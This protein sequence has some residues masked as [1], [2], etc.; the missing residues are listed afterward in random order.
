MEVNCLI[1]EICLFLLFCLVYFSEGQH[2]RIGV[3]ECGEFVL[4]GLLPLCTAALN[5]V[6]TLAFYI[7]GGRPKTTV[8]YD[9]CL[10]KLA[11]ALHLHE[12]GST[13]M[14]LAC[15]DQAGHKHA[16]R[17]NCI[18]LHSNFSVTNLDQ[19]WCGMV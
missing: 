8:T 9:C 6:C 1:V 10:G 7:A 19:L 11:E 5:Q 2:P 15:S 12:H 18:A 13:Y 14:H 3:A 17:A 4:T 16:W